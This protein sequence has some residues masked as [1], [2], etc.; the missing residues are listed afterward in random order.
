MAKLTVQQ[1]AKWLGHD[2]KKVVEAIELV[3]LSDPDAAWTHAEDMGHGD[4]AQIIEEIYFQYGSLKEAIAACKEDLGLSHVD[5]S[6]DMKGL[7]TFDQL[8]EKVKD[9]FYKNITISVAFV[10]K[11]GT[12]RHMAFR[13]NLKS[14]KKSDA[15]KTDAQI[16]MLKNNK[17]LN[18]YDT[19]VFIKKKRELG[20]DDLAAKESF[21]NINLGNVLAFL[22]GGELFDMR[23][24]N[25]IK[26]RFGD[27]V[28]HSLTKGMVA[29][30]RNDEQSSELETKQNESISHNKEKSYI[31]ESIL[32]IKGINKKMDDFSDMMD[33]I[34]SNPEY[35]A[36]YKKI[37][38]KAIKEVMDGGQL[39]T[40]TIMLKNAF[41]S[42][43]KFIID[44][45]KYRGSTPNIPMI[46]GMM[47]R[48]GDVMSKLLMRGSIDETI[49]S[50]ISMEKYIDD[51]TVKEEL[52]KM[53]AERGKDKLIRMIDKSKHK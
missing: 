1:F 16:N 12:V 5:E 47:D 43:P 7:L 27:D 48:I 26:E 30:M 44:V 17:L 49:E 34:D 36:K 9:N 50:P 52:K 38:T 33:V 24:K 6:N 25:R 53:S 39:T 13:R 22:T 14:Y 45:L 41:F 42:D 20:S 32:R 28:Y 40:H 4:I 51:P 8:P 31:R 29:V 18:V 23:E 3:K 10:K 35:L 46:E 11:D 37:I 19:N 2:P 21:R 15:P